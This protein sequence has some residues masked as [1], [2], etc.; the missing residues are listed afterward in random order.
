MSRRLFCFGLF[1][2]WAVHDVEEVATAS[3]WSARTTP[4]LLADGWPPGLVEVVGSTTPRF[5]LAAALVGVAVLSAALSGVRSDGHAAFFRAAVLV[6]G[7]HGLVHVA[8]AVLL[9]DYVP[10]LVTA[11]LLVIPYAFWHGRR[12]RPDPVP[13][14]TIAV[15]A[16]FA[17]ALT[18]AAQAVARLLLP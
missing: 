11:L 2:A 6:F 10:G 18:A 9:R 7:W 14:K 5:A 8:Q 13:G 16:G 3:W 12:L 4:R 17:V 1:V 15:V